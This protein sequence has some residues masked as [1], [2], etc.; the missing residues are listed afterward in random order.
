MLNQITGIIPFHIAL[1]LKTYFSLQ[2]H[3]TLIPDLRNSSSKKT[4]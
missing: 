2:Q 3:I 4:F 1:R